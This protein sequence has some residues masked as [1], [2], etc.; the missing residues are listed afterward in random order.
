MFDIANFA[1][2]NGKHACTCS[3]KPP[4]PTK[5]NYYVIS[6]T[7]GRQHYAKVDDFSDPEEGEH[8]VVY[9]GNKTTC[10]ICT[11]LQCEING[12]YETDMKLYHFDEHE[13]IYICYADHQE[14]YA[15]SLVAMS[16][17]RERFQMETFYVRDDTYMQMQEGRTI[18]SV[19]WFL[20]VDGKTWYEKAYGAVPKYLCQQ[21]RYQAGVDRLT[22]YVTSPSQKPSWEEF[23]KQHDVS[24]GRQKQLKEFYVTSETIREFF[25][26][27]PSIVYLHRLRNSVRDTMYIVY[28][29]KIEC[30]AEKNSVPIT[31][32]LITTDEANALGLEFFN[33]TK[34]TWGTMFVGCQYCLDC[35]HNDSTDFSYTDCDS[36]TSTDTYSDNE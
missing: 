13:D 24:D 28:D 26:K 5:T 1:R 4:P 33:D 31:Y 20:I 10:V 6:T 3:R 36:E 29:L 2:K 25:K 27:L 8:Y 23:V 7:N 22:T 32:A 11:I 14:T 9:V 16:F 30:T 19:D 18:P 21:E 34:M 17:V 35:C 15:L 12:P